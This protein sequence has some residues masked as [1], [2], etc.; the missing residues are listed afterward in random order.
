MYRDHTLQ[1]RMF[2][3]EASAAVSGEIVTR[4]N[5]L[6]PETLQNIPRGYENLFSAY[7]FK[8]RLG[9]GASGAYV[10]ELKVKKPSPEVFRALRDKK[11]PFA[12]LKRYLTSDQRPSVFMKLY[13]SAV[14]N[15]GSIGDERPFREVHTL[16]TLSGLTGFS[17]VL[18]YG[19]VS[20]ATCAQMFGTDP[21]QHSPLEHQPLEMLFV[22]MTHPLLEIKLD[23]ILNSASS[24]LQHVFAPDMH[25]TK[26]T[27]MGIAVGIAAAYQRARRAIPGFCHNDLHPG[28]VFVDLERDSSQSL[29]TARR[30]EWRVSSVVNTLDVGAISYLKML[31]PISADLRQQAASN[32]KNIIEW[33]RCGI[34]DFDL[35]KSSKWS[36]MVSYQH[37]KKHQTMSERLIQW[38]MHWLPL[39]CV[40]EW[41]NLLENLSLFQKGDDAN[42]KRHLFTYFMVGIVD[43]IVKSDPSMTVKEAYYVAHASVSHLVKVSHL[44]NLSFAS[45]LLIHLFSVSLSFSNWLKLKAGK[46]A[47]KGAV[48]L[49]NLKTMFGEMLITYGHVQGV[50]KRN[51]TFSSVTEVPTLTLAQKLVEYNNTGTSLVDL[52]NLLKNLSDDFRREMGYYPGSDELSI[53]VNLGWN[54]NN[55]LKINY[56][57]VRLLEA[58]QVTTP[59]KRKIQLVKNDNAFVAEVA[60]VEKHLRV[61][62]KGSIR[63]TVDNH[64]LE[65]KNI[66]LRETDNYFNLQLT[67]AADKWFQWGNIEKLNMGEIKRRGN[68]ENVGHVR[69]RFSRHGEIFQLQDVDNLLNLFGLFIAG[70]AVHP[71]TFLPIVNGPSLTI[72]LRAGEKEFS[73]TIG[74]DQPRNVKKNKDDNSWWASDT[75][76]FPLFT[77]FTIPN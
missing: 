35:V 23:T 29:S 5:A 56:F 63:V 44:V 21:T 41:K 65:L 62:G 45:A 27:M 77:D 22:I 26:A 31:N 58:F 12:M 40:F 74:A 67:V 69:L 48:A 64:N 37:V 73:A 19:I 6:Q 38:L 59:T 7:S 30:P 61:S 14:T 39:E 16:V 13:T 34:I 72:L 18:D 76:S 3:P 20:A 47:W 10:S 32:D 42:D 68:K 17:H 36:W 52:P 2:L 71:G 70:E 43:F 54:A 60:F 53:K 57:L 25:P 50:L 8:K 33:P 66:R 28:N 11:A 49:G 15:Y 46:V 51:L 55:D 4:N 9:G 24:D 1:A 75:N